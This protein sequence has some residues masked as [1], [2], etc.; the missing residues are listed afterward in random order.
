MFHFRFVLGEKH[1]IVIPLKE[2][3]TV[4]F[5]ATLLTQRQTSEMNG[6]EHKFLMLD[7]MVIG[8]YL[9]TSEEH[10]SGMD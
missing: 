7:L 3:T 4:M 8:N 1:S 6:T 9:I 5:C 10:L 2:F